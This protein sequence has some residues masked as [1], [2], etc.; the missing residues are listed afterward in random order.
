L[1]ETISNLLKKALYKNQDLLT[2]TWFSQFL[3][4]RFVESSGETLSWR[5]SLSKSKRNWI[6]QCK[7][8]FFEENETLK[9]TRISIFWGRI[10]GERVRKSRTK[11]EISHNDFYEKRF[12]L[13]LKNWIPSFFEKEVST[14]QRSFC[15][16]SRLSQIFFLS[17]KTFSLFLTWC[18]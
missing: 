5:W 13:Y 8:Y 2:K 14:N 6:F 4:K 15:L 3:S 12:T 17:T 18:W 11:Q 10:Q 7:G 1:W 16:K 9:I